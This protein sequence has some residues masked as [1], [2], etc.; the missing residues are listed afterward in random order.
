MIH[1]FAHSHPFYKA[2]NATVYAQLVIATIW[3][4]YAS[5]IA[6]F[7]RSKNGRG[8]IN[9]LK[10]QFDGSAHWDIEV[11]L[12]MDFLLNGKWNDQTAITLHAFLEKHISSFHSLQRCGDHVTVDISSEHTRVGHMLYNI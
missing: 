6:P 10:A 5:T 2:Y 3:S 4:Q 8:N 7:K 1:R 11:K 9:A 12:H